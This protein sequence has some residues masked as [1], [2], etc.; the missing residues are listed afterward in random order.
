MPLLDYANDALEFLVNGPGWRDK[1]EARQLKL[2]ADRMIVERARREERARQG[3]LSRLGEMS[4]GE[5]DTI[6]WAPGRTFNAAPTEARDGVAPSEPGTILDYRPER[7]GPRLA[8]NKEQRSLLELGGEDLLDFAMMNPDVYSTVKAKQLERSMAGPPTGKDRFGA[9]DGVGVVDFFGEGGPQVVIEK[10][11][12]SKEPRNRS[13]SVIGGKLVDNNTGEVIG[14][15]GEPRPAPASGFQWNPDGTQS[16]IPG[17][18]ADPKN[19]PR[20]V[21]TADERRITLALDNSQKAEP[22][23]QLLQEGVDILGRYS[24][25]LAAPIIGNFGRVM[26]TVG[27]GGDGAAD[28]ERLNSISKRLGAEALQLFSGSDTERELMVALQTTIDPSKTVEANLRTAFAQQAAVDILQQ[29]PEYMQEWVN[30]YGSLNTPNENGDVF[31]KAWRQTQRDQFAASRKRIDERVQSLR[32]EA[33]SREESSG[34]I[35]EGATA[36]NP[37]TGERLVRRGGQWVKQ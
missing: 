11:R 23:R 37:K 15:F 31:S 27:L 1:K 2:E 36:T 24:S 13:T 9:V 29:Y 21:S 3:L 16:P 8:M 28:Y 4:A 35:P 5:G 32:G 10:P 20:K 34:E 25:N 7:D 30:R 12:E 26:N 14:D 22:T 19:A 33:P 6:P 17:G 18:P